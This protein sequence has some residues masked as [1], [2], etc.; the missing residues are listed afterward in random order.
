M[1]ALFHYH[2]FAGTHDLLMVLNSS[3]TLVSR[4]LMECK[5][6]PALPFDPSEEP[7]LRLFNGCRHN[8]IKKRED[9][10]PIEE[11]LPQTRE[12]SAQEQS[13]FLESEAVAQQET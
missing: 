13:G 5:V 6:H 4:M 7:D 1:R 10:M 9:H 3:K 8:L 2:Q 11:I 12:R